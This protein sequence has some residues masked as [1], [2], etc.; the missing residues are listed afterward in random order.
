MARKRYLIHNVASEIG[1]PKLG[2]HL[3]KHV[4]ST[5]QVEAVFAAV[6]LSLGLGDARPSDARNTLLNRHPPHGAHE[7]A[8]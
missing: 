7:L 6:D 5:S 2:K 8:A 1:L 4:L 3:P